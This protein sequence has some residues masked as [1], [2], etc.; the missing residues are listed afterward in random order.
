MLT[1]VPKTSSIITSPT[2]IGSLTEAL[3]ISFIT[4][5]IIP[6][7]IGSSVLTG[8]TM[9]SQPSILTVEVTILVGFLTS[10]NP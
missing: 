6:F 7:G 5:N 10:F 2:L 8:T 1:P 3:L 4:S 9:L